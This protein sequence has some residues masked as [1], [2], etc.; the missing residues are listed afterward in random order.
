MAEIVFFNIHFDVRFHFFFDILNKSLASNPCK[1][2]YIHLVGLKVLKM[3]Q[4]SHFFLNDLPIYFKIVF[5]N[6]TL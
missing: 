1:Y 2:G 6:N 5:V 4:L 3:D